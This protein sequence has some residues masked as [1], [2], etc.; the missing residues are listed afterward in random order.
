MDIFWGAFPSAPIGAPLAVASAI[1]RGLA[2]ERPKMRRSLARHLAAGLHQLHEVLGLALPRAL[3][4][5]E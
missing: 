4:Y 1:A 3:A 2:V 5:P